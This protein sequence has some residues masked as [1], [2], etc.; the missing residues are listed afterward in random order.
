M[1]TATSHAPHPPNR[2]VRRL[3]TVLVGLALTLA[4]TVAAVGVA[5]PA[6]AIPSECEDPPYTASN[7]ARAYCWGG[8][9]QHKLSILCTVS[10]S[11]GITYRRESPWTATG[12]MSYANCTGSDRPTLTGRYWS[13]R[14]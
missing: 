4:S 3:S 10:G 7:W 14:G 12:Q 2:V 1:N 5:Q 11:S 8:T 9:G 13:F 6:Q